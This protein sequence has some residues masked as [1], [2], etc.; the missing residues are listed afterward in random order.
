MISFQING[1]VHEQ[2][3]RTQDTGSKMDHSL[4]IVRNVGI[5]KWRSI[6]SNRDINLHSIN[7]NS[8]GEIISN[9]VDRICFSSISRNYKRFCFETKWCSL[10]LFQQDKSMLGQ[11][12][13]WHID[14]ARMPDNL[15][16]EFFVSLLCEFPCK[17]A[18]K[19]RYI[20][21]EIIINLESK[22]SKRRV[23]SK[24]SRVG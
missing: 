24:N 12:A 9:N 7:P 18:S 6:L 17:N 14:W 22:G 21:P 13:S 3:V 1:M 10:T 16:I 19:W 23:Q 4:M 15:G 11:K 20:K 5:L 2:N 8:F